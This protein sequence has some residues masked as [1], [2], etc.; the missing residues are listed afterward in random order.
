[1]L[2]RLHE[3]VGRAVTLS[4]GVQIAGLGPVERPGIQDIDISS[5]VGG[6]MELQAK[7]G[8]IMKLIDVDA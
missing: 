2:V 7:M 6:H 1:M 5:V 4:S 8:E 3:V